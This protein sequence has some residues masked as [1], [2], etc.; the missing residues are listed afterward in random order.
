VVCGERKG[1]LK[2]VCSKEYINVKDI[3]RSREENK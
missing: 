1:E 3:K 2:M